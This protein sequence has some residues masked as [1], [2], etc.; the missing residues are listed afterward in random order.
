MEPGTRL[1]SG[2][3]EGGQSRAGWRGRKRE[4]E[5]A[6]DG[7]KLSPLLLLIL[8]LLLLLLICDNT[9]EAGR[10]IWYRKTPRRCYM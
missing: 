1:E 7:G 9:T 4:R 5:R 8:L 2:E 3:N 10:G 6:C